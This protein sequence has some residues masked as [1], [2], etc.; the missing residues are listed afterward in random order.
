MNSA[1]K[2]D[3]FEAA[4]ALAELDRASLQRL[5][6][7]K[8]RVSEIEQ[9]NTMLEYRQ[10]DTERKLDDHFSR[11]SHLADPASLDLSGLLDRGPRHA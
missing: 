2:L 3:E 8:E 9:G 4:K 11:A 10:R 1:K 7:V 5:E 6:E